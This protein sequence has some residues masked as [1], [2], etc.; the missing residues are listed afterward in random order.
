MRRLGTELRASLEAATSTYQKAL[1]AQWSVSST[2][3][4]NYLFDR[5]LDLYAERYRLGF[6]LEP[7][8]GHEMM[9]GRVSIPY[10]TQAGVV[11]LKFRCIADHD[12]KVM[13]CPKYLAE[14]GARNH[15]YNAR[16]VLAARDLVVICEGEFDAMAVSAIAGVPAVGYP[17]TYAWQQNKH[18]PR[19]F[20]GLDVVVVADGDKPGADAAKAVTRSI[21]DARVVHMPEG[22]DA[23]S[24]LVTSGADAFRER[25]G[26]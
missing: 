22:E 13:K 3:A 9:T 24:Y 26:V 14:D 11:N 16:A 10:L 12:C 5:G 8:P 4:R 23:N 2:E 17:G 21:P 7:Q 25:I 20:A 18:W 6:V 19:V 15:L 1:D